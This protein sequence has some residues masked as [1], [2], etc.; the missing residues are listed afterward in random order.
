MNETLNP[1]EAHLASVALKQMTWKP[2]IVRD[3][4]AKIVQKALE[5]GMLWPDEVS[6]GGINSL[7]PADMNCIGTAWKNL[8]RQGII[9]PTGRFRRSTTE[10]ARGRKVF[11]YRTAS[12][13]LARRWLAANGYAMPVTIVGQQEEMKLV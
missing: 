6:F 13:S 12:L 8:A 4:S 9:I 3:V 2:G 11:E 5:H 7:T 1:V 10:H